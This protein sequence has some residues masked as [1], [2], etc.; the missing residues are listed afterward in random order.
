M[1]IMFVMDQRVDRGSIQ[2]ISSYVRAGN[3]TG[4]EF[5]LYGQTDP[6]FPT[7]R[8]SRDVSAFDYVVFL[9]ESWRHWMSGLRMPRMFA[10][11]PRHR[12]AII[13]ADGMYN[14][15]VCTDSYDRNH[16]SEHVR[17]EW[18]AHYRVVADKIFQPTF[19]LR[20][21]GVRKLLFYGYDPAQ[22][23]APEASPAKAHDIL[24]VG[25]NWWRWRQISGELLPAIER[26]RSELGEIAF[27][28]NWWDTIPAGAAELGVESAFGIDPEWLRRLRIQIRPPVSY[29]EVVAVM[30][31]GRINIMTQ[32]PLFRE[33]KIL[34]SKYFEIF[35]ADT[36]PL[37]MLDPDY[38]EMVY[39]Q[40]GRELALCNDGIA[41]K[42]VDVLSHPR[43][44]REIVEEVR[45]HL[46]AHH[47]YRNRVQELVVALKE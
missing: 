20:E 28:G 32:R 13:D 4:H 36:T 22:Q 21:P 33:M 30:S 23:I 47:A 35:S 8:F 19:R 11:V 18:F 24:C 5:A 43:R 27:I 1:R 26:V 25:H 3:E 12:R 10:E 40:A 34:T 46:F 42:L 7:I 31:T 38:A 2:S 6:R 15:L 9:V 29:T 39:G 16:P 45:A 44:F 14:Q 17:A 41:E 37:V